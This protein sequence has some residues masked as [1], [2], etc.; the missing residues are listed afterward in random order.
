M[1][2]RQTREVTLFASVIMTIL[3]AVAAVIGGGVGVWWI[4]QPLLSSALP[5]INTA[6]VSERTTLSGIDQST[7]EKI[8]TERPDI[9]IDDLV[10]KNIIP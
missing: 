8:V 7:G 5:E 6:T 3:V 9:R 1:R 10:G 2:P 4:N